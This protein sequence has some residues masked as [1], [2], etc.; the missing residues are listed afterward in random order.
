[1]G[2][3]DGKM[4]FRSTGF[5]P[6]GRKNEGPGLIETLDM[7][8]TD[9]ETEGRKNGYTRAAEEYE[10]AFCSVKEEYKQVKELIG[11]Q[12]DTHD[13]QLE[14]LMEK[15]ELLEEEVRRLENQ[16]E[17]NTKAV[18][19]KYDIPV[20]QV[21][22]FVSSGTLITGSMIGAACILALIYEQKK[23]KLQKAEQQGY[24]EAREVFE[25]KINKEK[26]KLEK[27]KEKGEKEIRELVNM[28]GEVLDDIAEEQMKIAELKILL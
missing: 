15:L 28:V 2:L 25:T 7:L 1:M 24:L 18:A 6:V 16:V 3:M 10:K 13:I 11:F 4:G 21:R 9:V 27:L 23:R 8:F 20:S 12:K 17:E 22:G 19:H 26:R 5:Y 14:A